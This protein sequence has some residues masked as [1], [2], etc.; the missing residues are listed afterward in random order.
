M[1]WVVD[2]WLLHKSSESSA[3]PVARASQRFLSSLQVDGGIA[4]S[5]EVMAAYSPA[6]DALGARFGGKWFASMSKLEGKIDYVFD[7][8]PEECGEL[9]AALTGG[10]LPFEFDHDDVPYVVLAR[11]SPD[12]HLISGDVGDGDFAAGCT[13]W[14]RDNWGVCFHDIEPNVPYHCARHA[15]LAK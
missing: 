5:Q 9:R 15:C 6:V 11:R 1:I 14:L 13:Q 3:D 8:E 12:R 7:P 10:N 4:L 2:V